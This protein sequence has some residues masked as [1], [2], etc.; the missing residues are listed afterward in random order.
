MI[1]LIDDWKADDSA[2]IL[3]IYDIAG[4]VIAETTP[5]GST[6]NCGYGR[7]LRSRL[8]ITRLER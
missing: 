3:R 7:A 2:Q 8:F 5:R 6:S 1:G 4:N